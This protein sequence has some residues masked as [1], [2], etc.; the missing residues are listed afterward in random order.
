MNVTFSCQLH[1]AFMVIATALHCKPSCVRENLS[2]MPVT[3]QM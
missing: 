1:V 3:E 2:D